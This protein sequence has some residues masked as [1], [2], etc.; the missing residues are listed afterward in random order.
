MSEASKA[1]LDQML[2]ALGFAILGPGDALPFHLSVTET[3]LF[4]T[5]LTAEDISSIILCYNGIQYSLLS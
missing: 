2:V 5:I 1:P 3:D 4:V